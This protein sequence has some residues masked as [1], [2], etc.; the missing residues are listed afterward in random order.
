MEGSFSIKSSMNAEYKYQIFL[1]LDLADTQ[2]PIKTFSGP[3][4]FTWVT[5]H[6]KVLSHVSR[7][8]SHGRCRMLSPLWSFLWFSS[9]I[10]TTRSHGE[11]YASSPCEEFCSHWEGNHTR[12]FSFPLW[13]IDFFTMGMGKNK[14]MWDIRDTCEIY[15]HEQDFH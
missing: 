2:S 9:L 3:H 8:T 4:G 14:R 1:G 11:R 5:S 15:D 6:G 12:Q 13:D 10:G 7:E